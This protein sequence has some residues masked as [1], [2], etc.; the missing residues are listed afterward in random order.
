MSRKFYDQSVKDEAIRRFLNGESS[1]KI[2]KDMGI[3]SPDQIRKWVQAWRKKRNL[4]AKDYRKPDIADAVDEIQRL[5][6]RIQKFEEERDLG[7]KILSLLLTG[8]IKGWEELLIRIRPEEEGTKKSKIGQ[9]LHDIQRLQN[10]IQKIGAERDL[11]LKYI[12]LIVKEEIK[13]WDELL[14]RLRPPEE[15][16]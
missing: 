7:L 16:I 9:D 5:L 3:N 4:S 10:I 12:V 11:T 8:E 6:N 15:G 1:G 13:E 2:A 14:S